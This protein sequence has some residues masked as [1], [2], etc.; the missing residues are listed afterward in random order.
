MGTPDGHSLRIAHGLTRGRAIAVTVDGRPI[1]AFVGETVATALLAAGI[2]RFRRSVGRGTPRGPFCLMG[3]CKE[4][5][6]AVD[7][8][9]VLSCLARVVDGM[10]IETETRR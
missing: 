10:R 1:S 9:Q 3:V 5:L 2:R 6:V 8:R 7:G 4:C